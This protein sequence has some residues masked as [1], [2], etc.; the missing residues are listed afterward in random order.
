MCAVL[1]N[2]TKETRENKKQKSNQHLK[3]PMMVDN[4][5][6]IRKYS[7]NNTAQQQKLTMYL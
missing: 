7:R 2:E 6:E 5:N 3:Q 4:E 1:S